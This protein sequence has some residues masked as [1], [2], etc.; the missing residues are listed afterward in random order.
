MIKELLKE[1]ADLSGM[2]VKQ[3]V[4][5]RPIQVAPKLGYE[6]KDMSI[7]GLK[8]RINTL[9]GEIAGLESENNQIKKNFTKY[10]TDNR[11]KSELVNR[12]LLTP[13][14]NERIVIDDPAWKAKR[15][16]VTYLKTILDEKEMAQIFNE[17]NMLKVESAYLSDIRNEEVIILKKTL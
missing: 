1:I 9:T 8:D 5:S 4:T 12:F 2:E 10:L 16:E 15:E 14:I 7:Q 6:P 13:R 11:T 17:I 3:K